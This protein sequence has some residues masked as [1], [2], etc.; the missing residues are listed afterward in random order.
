MVELICDWNLLMGSALPYGDPNLPGD[1]T[2]IPYARTIAKPEADDISRSEPKPIRA[3]RTVEL[4]LRLF[5]KQEFSTASNQDAIESAKEDVLMA[6]QREAP[7][8][9]GVVFTDE[10]VSSAREDASE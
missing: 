2:H 10:S 7:E 4:C 8:M 1:L 3:E 5:V 9:Y 6:L